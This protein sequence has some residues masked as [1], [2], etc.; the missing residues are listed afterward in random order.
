VQCGSLLVTSEPDS[1]PIFSYPWRASHELDVIL[2]RAE[3]CCSR[4]KRR[5]CRFLLLSR[6]VEQ[7]R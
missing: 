5:K 3:T 2:L 6:G 7:C 4:K 1:Q